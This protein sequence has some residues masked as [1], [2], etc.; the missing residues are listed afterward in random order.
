MRTT[1]FVRR[2]S[3]GRSS[4][5]NAKEDTRVGGGLDSCVVDFKFEEIDRVREGFCKGV[6]RKLLDSNIYMEL[7]NIENRNI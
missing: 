4:K 6:A 5:D 7:D 2:G 1:S 3:N